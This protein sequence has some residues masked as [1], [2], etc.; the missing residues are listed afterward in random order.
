L[1]RFRTEKTWTRIK[2]KFY[3][4]IDVLTM[5]PVDKQWIH[6]AC[7][8]HKLFDTILFPPGNGG[9]DFDSTFLSGNPIFMNNAGW[10][11]FE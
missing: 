7:N 2:R 1:E 8:I 11:K 3:G 6:L 4:G 9:H 5:L 10:V